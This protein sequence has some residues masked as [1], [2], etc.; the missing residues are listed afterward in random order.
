MKKLKFNNKKAFL[1][2]REVAK[3]FFELDVRKVS[4][5]SGVKPMKVL[6]KVRLR[7]VCNEPSYGIE[8]T[9]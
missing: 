9:V 6:S 2:G 4:H 5:E 3:Q 8:D 1:S 7:C